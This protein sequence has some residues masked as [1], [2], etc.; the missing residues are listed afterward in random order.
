MNADKTGVKHQGKDQAP[1]RPTINIPRIDRVSGLK[2]PLP[3]PVPAPPLQVIPHHILRLELWPKLQHIHKQGK[4]PPLPQQRHLKLRRDERKQHAHGMARRHDL[5]EVEIEDARSGRG[6]AHEEQRRG[7]LRV[8]ELRGRVR[9][10][11]AVP[12][13][14]QRVFVVVEQGVDVCR[15]GTGGLP[16]AVE[17]LVAANPRQDLDRGRGRV[18]GR[19]RVPRVDEVVP[20]VV[21]LRRRHGQRL[22][23]DPSVAQLVRVAEMDEGMAN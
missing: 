3:H 14:E 6:R 10:G 18:F 8:P 1:P 19:P 20:K 13:L 16:L 2:R 7:V 11:P 9:N 4:E 15:S 12:V 21:P 17:A 23:R 5:R 22:D